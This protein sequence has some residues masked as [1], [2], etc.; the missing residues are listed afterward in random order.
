MFLCIL[1]VR[2]KKRF[3]L[4][5]GETA[6]KKRES[7]K[8]EAVFR[9]GAGTESL[10]AVAKKTPGEIFSSE[11]IL[12]AAAKCERHFAVR[13]QA[14]RCGKT[15]NQGVSP[16]PSRPQAKFFFAELAGVKKKF[17]RRFVFLWRKNGTQ[18]GGKGNSG[19]SA[20][21]SEAPVFF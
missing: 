3:E 2:N 12:L 15:A 17:C 6:K 19:F 21:G 14:E 8:T 5:C 20:M 18:N 10:L 1:S 7:P 4:T 9:Q 16:K 13:H 11:K